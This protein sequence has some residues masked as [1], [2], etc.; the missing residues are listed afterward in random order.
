MRRE[1]LV[2]AVAGL[3]VFAGCSSAIDGSDDPEQ[4]RPVDVSGS[5]EVHHIDVGQADSTLVV[6]PSNE[7]ILIDTGDY[8]DDGQDVIDYLETHDVDRIDHLITTHGHADHIGGHPA[9]IEHLEEAGDGVGAIYDSG[10]PHP[11]ATYERYL[12]AVERYN[13]SFYEVAAGD[14]LPLADDSLEATVLN[15]PDGDTSGDVDTN[16]IVLSLAFGD[17][18]Y[19]TTGDLDASGERRLVEAYGDDLAADAY[20]AG[21]HGSSTSSNAPFLDRVDPDIAVVSSPL[22][23]GYGHPHD[24]VLAAFASRGIETYWTGVHGD[25]VVTTTGT[26]V[27]VETERNASTDPATLLERKHAVQSALVSPLAAS[28]YA[29]RGLL[30][31]DSGQASVAGA[32]AHTVEGAR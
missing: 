6:T 5:L 3:L 19:L 9:I 14:R 4:E 1:L 32:V 29:E 26:A 16:G 13:V 8:R 2:V 12:D 7:T 11:T 10:V 22:D 27:S 23:S 25:I 24:E 30:P 15:P 17:F 20:Q 28:V 21:H 31:P 18:S